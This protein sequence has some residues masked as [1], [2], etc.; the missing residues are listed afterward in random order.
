MRTGFEQVAEI[1]FHHP[2]QLEWTFHE[3]VFQTPDIE[4]LLHLIDYLHQFLSLA[5]GPSL[6]DLKD[7]QVQFRY[8]LVEF[9]R[10]FFTD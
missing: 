8:R 3:Y 2:S 5:L 4:F 1:L 6:Q 10:I 7:D 9:K